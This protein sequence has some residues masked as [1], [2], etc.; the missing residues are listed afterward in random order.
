MAGEGTALTGPRVLPDLLVCPLCQGA[1]GEAESG[2]WASAAKALGQSLGVGDASHR[3]WACASCKAVFPVAQGI[4]DFVPRGDKGTT[5]DKIDYDAVHMIDAKVV[6]SIGREWAEV[7]RD[8]EATGGDL[9]EIG[10]GTG[11][12]TLGLLE[13]GVARSLVASDISMK[14]MLGLKAMAAGPA[15]VEMVVCDANRLNFRGESFDV[16]V[17]RSILH[18]L[19]GYE[20]T[21]RQV[22]RMLRPG[23]VGVFY[24][25]ILQG[26]VI[27][28][29]YARLA[30]EAD[31]AA[32]HPVF[33]DTDRN[34]IVSFVRHITKSTWYPQDSDSLAKIEDKYIFD[35]DDMARLAARAGYGGFHLHERTTA[36]LD[37]TYW[38]YF[39]QHMRMLGVEPAKLAGFKWI[40]AAFGQTWGLMFKHK[41]VAPMGFF[42]FRK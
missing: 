21:L 19:V 23:G 5:L 1:L 10:S 20:E 22:W 16:V 25:P 7:L 14:F 36:L 30:F 41:L 13:Q 40:G 12:L 35:L 34:K 38:S 39:V 31:A 33:S 32:Q 28:A 8:L 15:P 6:S 11:A 29:L 24:E 3:R 9:L 4:P 27:P 37:P 2:R 18:H 17:G 26:K 42:V